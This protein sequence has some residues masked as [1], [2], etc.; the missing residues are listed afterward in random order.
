M[1]AIY[2]LG[3]ERSGESASGNLQVESANLLIADVA[4][5]REI[6]PGARPVQEP[7]PN[8]AGNWRSFLKSATFSN[9]ESAILTRKCPALLLKGVRRSCLPSDCRVAITER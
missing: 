3:E 6:S 4:G 1:V 8:C 9:F 2:Q 5:N 7:P